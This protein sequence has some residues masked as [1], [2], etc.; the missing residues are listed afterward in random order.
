M[1]TWSA[2]ME[3]EA[4]EENGRENGA[5]V[6]M[7]EQEEEDMS[8]ED[9]GAKVMAPTFYSDAAKYWKVQLRTACQ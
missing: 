9:T 5:E 3:E 6:T 7:E 2:K 8:D 1:P 4:R